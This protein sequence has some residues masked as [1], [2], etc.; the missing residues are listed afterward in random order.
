MRACRA[1]L[2]RLLCSVWMKCRTQWR[3]EW[4]QCTCILVVVW[5]EEQRRAR[6]RHRKQTEKNTHSNR[7]GFVGSWSTGFFSFIRWVYSLPADLLVFVEI[8]ICLDGITRFTRFNS[9]IM[10][11]STQQS[12][13]RVGDKATDAALSEI[14]ANKMLTLKW[15]LS[16]RVFY[17]NHSLQIAPSRI[18]THKTRFL[19]SD[20][21]HWRPLGFGFGG[22]NM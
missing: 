11:I 10:W 5:I 22:Q 15:M 12:W 18:D 6:G 4:A 8:T 9:V 16:N 2:S 7:S 1:D 17:W 20:Y 19:A 3:R 14:T 21:P 13:L